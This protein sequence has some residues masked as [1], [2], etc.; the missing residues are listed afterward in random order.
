MRRPVGDDGATT[1]EFALVLPIF[2]VL[3]SIGAFF[4]WMA[5]AQTQVDR[6]ATRAARY[7]A[8]PT[9]AGTYD[10]CPSAI[11]LRLNKD[12]FSGKVLANEVTVRDRTGVVSGSLVC[13]SAIAPRGYVKVSIAHRYT[14]PFTGL[15]RT[16]TGT[17]G[18]FTVNGS[19]QARVES[20]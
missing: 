3:V 14:N 6:A 15:L 11:L 19:G 1:V 4:G 9:T 10:H 5:F 13:P 12:L 17:S 20:R 7:A 16:F 8:I 18:V 2:L